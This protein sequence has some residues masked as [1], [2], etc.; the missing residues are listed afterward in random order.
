MFPTLGYM[1]DSK[2]NVLYQVASKATTCTTTK[3]QRKDIC[4]LS[5]I[6]KAS[7]TNH[8]FI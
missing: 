7:E 6:N 4:Q 3:N 2:S 8:C 1:E 5:K